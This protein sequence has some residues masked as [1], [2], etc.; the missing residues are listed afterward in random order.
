MPHQTIH[1]TPRST[2]VPPR[3]AGWVGPGPT[4]PTTLAG[5]FR[6]VESAFAVVTAT[7]AQGPAAFRVILVDPTPVPAE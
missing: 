3:F 5:K 1:P 4:P 6:P 7:N 2:K